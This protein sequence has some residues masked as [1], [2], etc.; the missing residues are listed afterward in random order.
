M[1][2]LSYNTPNIIFCQIYINLGLK[3]TIDYTL[4][5]GKQII[6]IRVANFAEKSHNT[7][8]FYLIPCEV[9]ASV[10]DTSPPSQQYSA[11][12]GRHFKIK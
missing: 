11:I 10:G 7:M 9:G 6:F 12:T 3:I 2:L 1:V 5:S 4:S 8:E